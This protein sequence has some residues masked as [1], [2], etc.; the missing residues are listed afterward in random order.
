MKGTKLYHGTYVL[1]EEIGSG[2]FARI[3]RAQD[4]QRN[5]LVAI[6]VAS[7]ANDPSYAKSLREEAK[8]IQKF[9]H[10]NIV[11][12]QAIPRAEKNGQLFYANAIELPGHPVFFVME[13]LC[14]GTLDSYLKQ[15]KQLTVPE[16]ATI[17]IQV[18]R[19]LYHMHQ[20]DYAHN[21]LKLENIMFRQPI[22]AGEPFSPVL[23]DF[24][25][26]TRVH[27]PNA[28]SLYIMPPEQLAKVK[29]MAP[30]EMT[31]TID[32]TKMDVWSL[33]V[34][35]YRMLGG[36]LPFAGRNERTL[37]Q[38]IHSSRPMDLKHLVQDIPPQ[39]DRL[40]IDG[41]LAKNPEHRLNLVEL[42]RELGNFTDGNVVA[43]Y[44]A[45]N[46]KTGSFFGRFRGR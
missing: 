33:G 36:Q 16:A 29:L 23:I 31:E 45:D 38:Q 37:T 17:T 39:L 8:I 30:P 10:Q 41:C 9:D 22:V 28:G 43:Q 44:S 7:N 2:G 26:A 32:R 13:Y 3:W 25:I 11:R 5:E 14:G 40:V 6:K 19:G 12:L 15:V 27:Q 42:G 4:Q 34:V 24:G 1:E 20:N 21:D 46:G 35:L 18:A